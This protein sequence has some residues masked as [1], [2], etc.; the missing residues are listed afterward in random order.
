MYTHACS[1]TV[2]YPIS[3]FFPA[4]DVVDIYWAFSFTCKPNE[5]KIITF[6]IVL[7]SWPKYCLAHGKYSVHI[8]STN[9]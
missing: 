7:C 8:W 3:F 1:I 6:V 2:L 4:S 5:N 9:E